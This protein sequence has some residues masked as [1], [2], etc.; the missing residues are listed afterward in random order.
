MERSA[1]AVWNGGLKDGSGKFSVQSGL[2]SDVP[3]DFGKRF[4]DDPGTNPEELI[5]AAHSACFSM[6]LS[7]ELGKRGINAVSVS[8]KA[9][10]T[11]DSGTLTRSH[12]ETVVVAPGADPATAAEAWDAAKA[13]CPISK[14]LNMEITL[15]AKLEA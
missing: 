12:L 15:D 9:T 2:I 8:T 6:A 13:G 14:A 4:G 7:S 5:A 1:N 10:V 11:L 3:Y